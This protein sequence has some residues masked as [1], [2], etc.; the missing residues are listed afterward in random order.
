MRSL[1]L[2]LRS[3]CQLMPRGENAVAIKIRGILGWS[4]VVFVTVFVRR[5]G[6]WFVVFGEVSY[7]SGVVY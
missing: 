1:L 6:V 5:F 2:I 4:V 3:R 7:V